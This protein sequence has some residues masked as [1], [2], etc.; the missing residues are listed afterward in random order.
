MWDDRDDAIMR[1][2][3]CV[4]LLRGIPVRIHDIDQD[5]QVF[6]EYLGTDDTGSAPIHD[7]D[8]DWT[9]V[10]AGFVNKANGKLAYVQ[11][12]PRRRWKHGLHPDNVK[13]TR[14]ER[15]IVY[16]AAFGRTVM[17]NYPTEGNA[18]QQVRGKIRQGM[19]FSREYA[20]DRNEL[21][22]PILR[23]RGEMVGWYEKD[24]VVLGDGWQFLRE[25]FN[26]IK[27]RREYNEGL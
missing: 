2:S 10:P 4:V 7:P 5:M 23:Y 21:G 27:D 9:P 1:L 15:H 20:I 8:W 24:G 26:D 25:E 3:G 11:R 14:Q 13:V 22:I 16:T 17:G 18:L 6:Y 19:A 12:M